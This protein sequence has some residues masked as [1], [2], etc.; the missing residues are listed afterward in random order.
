MNTKK[1]KEAILNVL[2]TRRCG[3]CGEVCDVRKTICD[4]CEREPNRIE[5]KICMRC[6]HEKEL[7]KCENNR[8]IFYES[9][10]APFHYRGGPRSAVLKLKFHNRKD[11]ADSLGGEMAECVRERYKGYS[12]DVCTYMP[13]HK[14]EVKERGFNHAEL[15]AR[16]LSE[17]LGIPCLPLIQKDFETSP[18][19]QLPLYRR[20][21]NL[22]GALSFDDSELSDLTDMRILLCDD[23]KTSGQSLNECAQILLFNGAA[24][25]RCITVCIANSDHQQI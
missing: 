20:T 11:L 23:I 15:L 16:S 8:F 18:Q 7:C 14:N 2:F 25:V 9:V 24:E 19:H 10:C 12:F 4:S 1:L 21:G 13:S 22:A 6:G 5:G 17:K 3:I